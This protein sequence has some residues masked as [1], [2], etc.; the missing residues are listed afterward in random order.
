MNNDLPPPEGLYGVWCEPKGHMNNPQWLASFD[1]V[2]Y[3]VAIVEADRMNRLNK[4]WHYYAKPIIGT[5][6]S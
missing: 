1:P 3:E 2:S 6:R 5:Y 4:L